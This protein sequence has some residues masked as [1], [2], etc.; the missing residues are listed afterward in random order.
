[1]AYAKLAQLPVEY[2]LYTS[3]FG[4]LFY[5]VF[6]TSKDINIGPVAVASIVT[7]S[8]VAEITEQYPEESHVVIASTIAMFAGAAVAA[9]GILRLGWLVDLIS[10]PAVS[11]FISGTAITIT[12]AQIPPLLGIGGINTREPAF[13]ILINIF[14]KIKEAKIDAAPGIS[15]LVVLYLIKWGCQWM[16]NKKPRQAKTI[17]FLSTMRTVLIIMVFVLISFLVNRTRREDPLFRILGFI[18]KGVQLFPKF[19]S[20]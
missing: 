13:K 17:L 19:R 3:V 7:G 16:A 15:A 12:V 10:L 9:I 4:G 2:G 8:I 6:G 11:S 5:W 20:F 14:K 1:M 18:P